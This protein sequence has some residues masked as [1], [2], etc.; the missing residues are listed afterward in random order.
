MKVLRF[1][2]GACDK[3]VNK[4]GKPKIVAAVIPAD[5]RTGSLVGGLCSITEG[6]IYLVRERFETLEASL[7]TF[8]HEMGHWIDSN[9]HADATREHIHAV[10][11]VASAM[12][13]VIM[14]RYGEVEKIR[15]PNI[16]YKPVMATA[17]PVTPTPVEGTGTVTPGSPLEKTTLYGYSMEQLNQMAIERGLTPTGSKREIANQLFNFTRSR[18]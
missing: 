5:L 13:I 8:Y 10:Q 11:A 12:S 4:E 2:S 9:E 6:T 18:Q 16:S 14:A 17:A 7:S 3:C 1:L 15:Y